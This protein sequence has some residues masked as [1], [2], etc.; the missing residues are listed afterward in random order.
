MIAALAAGGS[1]GWMPARQ[2]RLWGWITVLVPLAG[3]VAGL[4]WMLRRQTGAGCLLVV[5][6][7]LNAV[8]GLFAFV[9][10]CSLVESRTSTAVLT[11]V[12][13][14]WQAERSYHRA[15]GVYGDF[16]ELEE[17]KLVPAELALV[18][19]DE[20]SASDASGTVYVLESL[21]DDSFVIAAHHRSLRVPVRVN[22]KGAMRL[23]ADSGGAQ[24]NPT[25]PVVG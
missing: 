10:G 17:E 19:N 5:A 15:H 13:S 22:E 6:V 12:G 25:E 3:L 14:L 23:D 8:Y 11:G 20:A 21:A 1:A 4:V 16:E 9:L 7:L 24:P 2:L 18:V